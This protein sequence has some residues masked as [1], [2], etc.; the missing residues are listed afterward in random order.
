[1]NASPV[2]DAATRPCG[3][4][5]YPNDPSQRRTLLMSGGRNI[6][7]GLH[8]LDARLREDESL[9][10]AVVSTATEDELLTSCVELALTMASSFSGPMVTVTNEIEDPQLAAQMR[11]MEMATHQQKLVC[12]LLNL[13]QTLRDDAAEHRSGCETC[14]AAP[15]DCPL[16]VE[17]IFARDL[18][19]TLASQ[20]GQPI[21]EVTVGGLDWRHALDI[22]QCLLE[23][24]RTQNGIE[25]ADQLSALSARL[26]ELVA[27][28][29]TPS[30]S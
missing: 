7:L 28:H 21:T 18:A 10:Q 12:F 17:E 25:T 4:I 14:T 27:L 3:L 5:H 30:E 26:L 20:I 8:L 13:A 2:P 29:E 1:M 24:V 9:A 23:A 19:D 6:G 11:E 22:A 15:D 16:S